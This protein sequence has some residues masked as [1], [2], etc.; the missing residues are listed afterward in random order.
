[1]QKCMVINQFCDPLI[2]HLCKNVI[3]LDF[4]SPLL[5]RLGSGLRGISPL[6]Y[7]TQTNFVKKY[8][9]MLKAN[10]QNMIRSRYP[11]TPFSVSIV[12]FKSY[13]PDGEF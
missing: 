7:M 6:R 11:F 2:F 10:N 3:L 8:T 9:E 4:Q 13:G 5:I 1:M 12:L